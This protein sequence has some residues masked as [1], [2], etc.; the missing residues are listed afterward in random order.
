[1]PEG[2]VAPIGIIKY[3]NSGILLNKHNSEFMKNDSK[4]TSFQLRFINI[5]KKNLN[6]GKNDKQTITM[7]FL[8]TKKS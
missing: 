6:H 7:H 5:S 8:Q 4:C 3:E 2:G 1:M